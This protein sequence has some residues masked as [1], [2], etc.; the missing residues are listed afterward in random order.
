MTAKQALRACER[1]SAD[2]GFI[3]TER[4]HLCRHVDNATSNNPEYSICIFHRGDMID[5]L[6][7]TAGFKDL[8]P[9]VKTFLSFCK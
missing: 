3:V 1:L 6:V 5:R 9:Q 4:Q 8:I 7:S 2:H